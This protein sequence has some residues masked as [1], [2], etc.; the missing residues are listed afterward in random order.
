MELFVR[1]SR[2]TITGTIGA[3]W[4]GDDGRFF[5]ADFERTS[6]DAFAY[7]EFGMIKVLIARGGFILKW[8]VNAV[9]QNSLVSAR[10]WIETLQDGAVIGLEQ[11]FHG[12]YCT[13]G[14]T[15]RQA[16]ERISAS[17]TYQGVE[18][19]NRSFVQ[20]GD[21]SE[22]DTR[23]ATVARA[24][25]TWQ[26][27]GRNAFFETARDLYARA[28]VYRRR[29]WDGAV[30]YDSVGDE[31]P[32]TS[33]LG[34]D[35]ARAVEGSRRDRVDRPTR[36][37]WLTRQ[38][39]DEVMVSDEPRYDRD[40]AAIRA[41]REEPKWASYHRLLLPLKDRLGAPAL[42][43][44]SQFHDSSFPLLGLAG[45]GGEDRRPPSKRA[46]GSP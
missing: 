20:S 40:L 23:T 8:D 15:K 42:A 2:A 38:P 44:V 6:F 12:W 9:C 41:P 1:T 25:Q 27:H 21:V 5:T 4:I 46:S 34:R 45:E 18:L 11:N 24:Y 22:I 14:L 13:Y 37:G 19:G 31:A 17:T 39:F 32:I 3:W 16:L 29:Y 28:V 10:Q 36:G 30:V 7:R 35:W 33:I 43:C 26:K